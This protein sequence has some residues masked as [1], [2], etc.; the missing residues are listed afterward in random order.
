MNVLRKFTVA[1]SLMLMAGIPFWCA[2]CTGSVGAGTGDVA[3]SA[4]NVPNLIRVPL[5]RQATDHTCGVASLQSILYYYGL[6][7]REDTLAAMLQTTDDGTPYRNMVS[8]AEAQGFKVSVHTKLTLEELRKF[9]DLGQPVLLA[10]QAW[11]GPPVDWS[12]YEEGH[13]V[14]AIG[15]DQGNFYFMDPSTLGQYTFIPNSEFMARW[16]D[17][18]KDGTHLDQFGIIITRTSFDKYDPDRILRLD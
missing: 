10:I 2:G 5:A 13:Y 18:D 1:F 12:T 3:P 6:P 11:M 16:H 7:F 15:Y 4:K 8:L 14:V 9:I 17:K